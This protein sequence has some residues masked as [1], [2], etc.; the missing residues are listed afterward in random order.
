[1][2]ITSDKFYQVDNRN[3]SFK[4]R[5]FYK[6]KENKNKKLV[7]QITFEGEETQKKMHRRE[8]EEDER[9]DLGG[10]EG[11]IDERKL[12]TYRPKNFTFSGEEVIY[13]QNNEQIINTTEGENN[14]ERIRNY[15]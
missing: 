13:E 7:R 8:L 9:D 1:M 11:D 14:E 12:N 15:K 6:K 2:S 5:N 10:S 3:I 4:G